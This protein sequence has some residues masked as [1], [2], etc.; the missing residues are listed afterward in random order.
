ML[1]HEQ[2]YP[3]PVVFY[4]GS[5]AA[6]KAV[7]PLALRPRNLRL[8]GQTVPPPASPAEICGVDAALQQIMNTPEAATALMRP[9][10]LEPSLRDLMSAAMATSRQRLSIVWWRMRCVVSMRCCLHGRL[11]PR[12]L[13]QGCSPHPIWMPDETPLALTVATEADAMQ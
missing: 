4:G 11:V 6:E 12:A 10:L 7:K 8:V 1:L 3:K 5:W 9:L 13:G 2:H